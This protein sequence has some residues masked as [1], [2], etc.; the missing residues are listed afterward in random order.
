MEIKLNLT[1]LNRV[2]SQV[3]EKS[4][5]NLGQTYLVIEELKVQTEEIEE[6]TSEHLVFDYYIVGRYGVE[7]SFDKR[8]DFLASSN[9]DYNFLAG[10]FNC[11][12]DKQDGALDE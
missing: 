12:V 5:K 11:L 8:F 1:A 7:N 4:Y 2:L 9:W 6:V 3:V 10:Y